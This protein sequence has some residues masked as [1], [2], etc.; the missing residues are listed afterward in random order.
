MR[1]VSFVAPD[2]GILTPRV[3]AILDGRTVLDLQAAYADYLHQEQGVLHPWRVAE[4]TIPGDMVAFLSTGSA[5]MAAC[6]QAIHWARLRGCRAGPLQA[7]GP[8]GAPYW[9]PPLAYGVDEVVVLA[10]LPHP[11]S[12]RDFYA[13]EEHARAGAARRGEEL[14]GEW[15]RIPV[16]YKG[17][18]GSVFGPEAEVPWPSYTDVLDFELEI[19][20]VIGKAGV[21]IRAE[22][23]SRYIFGYTILNDFSARD[24]QRMEMKV[25]LGPAKSKDF[26]TAMGP[27]LVTADELPPLS[28]WPL[29]VRVNGKT[30]FE[31]KAGGAY[32][33]FADMVEH[34]SR[35]EWLYPGDVLAS[36][37]IFGGCGLDVGRFLQPGDVIELE[38]GP[39]GTL[40]NRVGVP[41]ER[42][43]L[44]MTP[45]R[46]EPL[47][48]G[49]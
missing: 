10:P 29:R 33:S 41:K 22:E 26:A 7:Q 1:L 6:L 23:A 36:G 2:K 5:G 43:P 19:A 47:Q 28:D 27:A 12:I 15:Y 24:V 39:I 11:R 16:Y 3:G 25:R 20:A 4:A 30:W 45:R 32:W 17:N 35:D 31:G 42:R 21:N 40:R 13:Y 18:H 49:S 48:E 46:S 8:P 37:T 34:C 38:V 9:A 44:E 14:P